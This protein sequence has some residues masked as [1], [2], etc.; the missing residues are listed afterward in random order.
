MRNRSPGRRRQ[1]LAAGASPRSAPAIGRR[2]VT[3]AW[4][5]ASKPALS[6]QAGFRGGRPCPGRTPLG[7]VFSGRAGVRQRQRFGGK[8][9]VETILLLPAVVG[10]GPRHCRTATGSCCG[11]LP[12][13]TAGVTQEVATS[14]TLAEANLIRCTLLAAAPTHQRHGAREPPRPV[15]PPVHHASGYSHARVAVNV[16][17]RRHPRLTRSPDRRKRPTAGTGGGEWQP[18]LRTRVNPHS[19]RLRNY[20]T[21]DNGTLS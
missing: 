3:I 1:R 7:D 19:H 6:G 5:G 15:T 17:S 8:R 20:L 13:R 16:V 4:I 18:M 21:P 11:T 9:P 10:D 14:H 2:A 12:R